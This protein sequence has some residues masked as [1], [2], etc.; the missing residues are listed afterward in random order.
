MS[1]MAKFVKFFQV[2]R[3]VLNPNRNFRIFSKNFAQFPQF[4]HNFSEGLQYQFPS[5]CESL[6]LVFVCAIAQ[7]V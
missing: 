4:L 1:H 2:S 3:S 6:V 5:W 7:K